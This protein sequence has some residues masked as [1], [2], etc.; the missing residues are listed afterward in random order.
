MKIF[1][2]ILEIFHIKLELSIVGMISISVKHFLSQITVLGNF[3]SNF[4]K[5]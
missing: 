2:K 5:Y 1:G 3:N 4:E